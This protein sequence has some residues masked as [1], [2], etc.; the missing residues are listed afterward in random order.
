MS[1]SYILLQS[2]FLR[3][4]K[5]LINLIFLTLLF[6][7]CATDDEQ[8]L[9]IQELSEVHEYF[10]DIAFGSEFGGGYNNIRKWNRNVNIYVPETQYEQLNEELELIISELNLLLSKNVQLIKVM[11]EEDANYIIYFGDKDTYVQD[12]APGAA[13]QVENN[14]GLFLIFWNNWTIEGGSMYVDVVRTKD[15]NCQKHLLREELTQSLGLMNDSYSFPE[16]I[17]YQEWTCTPEYADI[18]KQLIQILYDPKISAGMSREDV[19]D[20]LQNLGSA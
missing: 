6:Q 16:S 10:L 11:N 1:Q 15:I 8:P 5:Y 4:H 20:Y 2:I 7:A 17:F 12:Y 14:W 18:D 19:I 9:V 13:S 3:Y